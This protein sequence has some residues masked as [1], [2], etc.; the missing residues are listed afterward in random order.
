MAAIPDPVRID[1]GMISGVPGSSPEVR[2]FKGVPFGAPP[3]GALRWREP[4]PVAHWDGVRK[5]DRFSPMCMQASGGRGGPVSGPAPSE[6]CLYLNVWTAANTA[7]ERRPV[8]VWNYGGG[9]TGGNGSSPQFDGEALAKKGVVLVTYNYRVGVFG[10]FAHP[11]LTKESPHHSSGNY[12]LMDLAA[13][14]RWVRKN[15]SSFGGDP[16]RVTIFGVS[17]GG[18]LV[19]NLVGSPEGKGLFQRA[20]SESC[21]WMGLSIG[22]PMTLAQAEAAGT[23]LGETL[24]APSLAA[25]RAKSADELLK[26]G[27]GT[28]PIVDG[29]FI[30]EPLSDIFDQG[31]ENRVEVL[32]GSNKDEGTFFSRPGGT[33]EQWKNRA[34]QRYG[35]LAD[36]FLKLY[37]A[38]SDA[39]AAASQL[40]NFR[41]ELAW[42]QL[43]WAKAQS[44]KSKAFLYYFTHE[45][46]T[47]PG[48]PSR[49]ATHGA[50][51][52]YVFDN[53]LPGRTPWT[54]LDR[55]LADTLSSYW[56]NF[57]AK[58]DPN[59]KGLPAWPSYR[60]KKSDRAMILGDQVEAGAPPLDAAKVAFYDAYYAE[61]KSR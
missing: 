11:E 42:N 46:P 30:P 3:V 45:P 34:K 29:W 41:D 12:A 58:G 21:G 10:F 50:E 22:A 55:Q 40:A 37:P 5:A 48:A 24:G 23:K 19:A 13:T 15:I 1:T 14:L 2:V 61:V 49:G 51:T 44:R 54:D 35:G 60:E 36:A 4:Q 47:A 57:A 7:A 25:L 52:A 43:T 39:Q 26:S 59:G 9:Y 20:I 8:M 28:G 6:D 32:V 53:L 38:D 33:A 56:A 17:A 31:R 16:A 27:R 18:G